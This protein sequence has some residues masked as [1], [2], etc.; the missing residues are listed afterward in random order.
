MYYKFQ[1][2]DEIRHSRFGSFLRTP[3][4][5]GWSGRVSD[6]SNR[7]SRHCVVCS[8]LPQPDGHD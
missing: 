1:L 3:N 6:E 4:P 8:K 5:L 7:R 2:T